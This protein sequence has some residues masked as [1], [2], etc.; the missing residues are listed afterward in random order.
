MQWSLKVRRALVAGS[1]LVLF[2]GVSLVVGTG[3]AADGSTAR[4]PLTPGVRT[5]AAAFV[6]AGGVPLAPRVLKRYSM[7]WAGYVATG[8]PHEFISASASWV[9]PRLSCSS[10]AK[11]SY[12]STW[13]AFDGYTIY[14]TMTLVGTA[15]ECSGTRQIDGAFY[16]FY[17]AQASPGFTVTPGTVMKAS[18]GHTAAG[19]TVTITDNHGHKLTG[20]SPAPFPRM[21]AEMIVTAWSQGATP[22]PLVNFHKLTF[23]SCDVN[24]KAIGSYTKQPLVEVTMKSGATTKATPGNLSG[25]NSFSVTWDHA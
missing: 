10:T 25:G 22:L 16:D 4:A 18:I 21:S 17:P 15:Y 23:T 20:H 5:V 13:V 2:L 9:V 24:G 11:K 1:V 6:A 19:T 14:N 7:T 8:P 3:G 12:A